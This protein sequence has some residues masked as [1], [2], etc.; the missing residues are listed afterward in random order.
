MDPPRPEVTVTDPRSPGRFVP[1]EEPAAPRLGRRGAA[2]LAVAALVGAAVLVAVDVVRDRRSDGVV[3]LVLGAPG[4][5]WSS[6][7]DPA[8]GTGTVTGPVRLYNR[9]PRDVRVLSADL[10]G[11][12]YDAGD[13]VAERGDGTVV[14]LE[15]TV[16]CPEDG[17]APP[18]EPEP[19]QLRLQVETPAGPRQVSMQGDG[20]PFGSVDDSVRSACA[21]PPL[22]DALQLTSTAVRLEDRAA[23][24]QV[25][26]ANAG[27]SPLRLLSLVPAR[28]LQVQSLDGGSGRLPVVLPAARSRRSAPARTFE[29]RLVV[30]CSALRSADLLTPFEELS[31]IV[32]TEDRSQITAVGALTRDPALLLRQLAR[33]TCSSG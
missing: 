27:R 33:R 12:R 23:V 7:H 18:H 30:L 1:V 21:H 6:T 14:W 4:G 10:G 16:R 9:G 13:V 5:G 28:G 31:A 20:L 25:E 26:V 2:L 22:G 17:S 19:S 24:L 15:R 32:E 3:R 8:T 29:V 11:L